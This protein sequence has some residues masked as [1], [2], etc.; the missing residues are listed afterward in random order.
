MKN[1]EA[2]YPQSVLSYC[3][4]C[5]SSS[6]VFQ[7]DDS[8]LCN[9][10]QFHFYPGASAA[11]AAI[12]RNN[13][14]KILFT[15]RAKD[16]AKGTLDLPGGFVSLMETAETALSREILEELHLKVTHLDYLGSFPNRYLFSGMIY[17]TL[18][19]VFLCEVEDWNPLQAADDVAGIVFEDPHH[20]SLERIGLE[21]IRNIV[22]FL[23]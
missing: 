8:F 20:L 5:G 3:P 19:L 13:E 21:S 11:V 16:P 9:S 23:I 6:F 22:K 15:L 17:F 12:I 7:K 18:D 4:R 14:G 1:S 2:N 10:C